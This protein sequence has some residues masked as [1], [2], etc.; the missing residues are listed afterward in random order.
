MIS[1]SSFTL[2]I[3]C[4]ALSVA[5]A[6]RAVERSTQTTEAKR[7]SKLYPRSI[8]LV[9]GVNQAGGEWSPLSSAEEDATRFAE[10]LKTRGFEVKLLLG[11]QAS[12]QG[13]LAQLQTELPQSISAEDRFILYFAGHGQ[14]QVTAKGAK[15]GYIVPSDGRLE[16]GKDL[17]HTYLSMRELTE[18]LTQH[19]DSKHALLLFDSCFSG[20]MFTRGGL[21]RPSLGSKAHLKLKGVMGLTAGSDNELARDGLFTPIL[22]EALDG[23][24]DTNQDEVISFQELALYTKREISL[25]QEGQTPQFGIISGSGQMVFKSRPVPPPM[26]APAG[27]SAVAPPPSSDA[28]HTLWISGGAGLTALGVGL[29]AHGAVRYADLESELSTEP[30]QARFQRTVDD[31][32][33]SISNEYSAGWVLAGVGALTLGYGLYQWMSASETSSSPEPSATSLQA[34][35]PLLSPSSVGFSYRW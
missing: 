19:I 9:I 35:T 11:S 5:H 26:V 27:V 17:W 1:L 24:A 20:M 15:V 23:E 4:L 32:F 34:F 28:G 8:A 6:E 33:S 13:I 2:L 21:R 25:R 7:P 12:K 3:T 30:D 10:H 29:I 18:L 16:G 31:R 14:T 22:L